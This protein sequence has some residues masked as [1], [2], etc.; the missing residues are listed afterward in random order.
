M[1]R[2]TGDLQSNDFQMIAVGFGQN[3][4][5]KYAG[6]GH[7][8]DPDIL[9]VGN[10][11]MNTTEWHRQFQKYRSACSFWQ[12]CHIGKGGDIK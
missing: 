12:P 4:L 6:P 3:D 1:W 2:T 11:G 5:E 9:E 7:W 10:T 8:N